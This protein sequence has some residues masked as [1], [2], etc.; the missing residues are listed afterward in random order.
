MLI[1]E[2]RVY[3]LTISALLLLSFVC[4]WMHVHPQDGAL[5][6]IAAPTKSATLKA[7][8]RGMVLTLTGSV[9]DQA[10]KV[11]LI[12]SAEKFFGRAN[13]VDQIEIVANIPAPIWVEQ[14]RA[15]FPLLKST[16]KNGAFGFKDKSVEVSGLVSGEEAKTKILRSID[17]LAGANL[18][19]NDQLVTPSARAVQSVKAGP[20]QLKLN[21]LLAGQTVEFD[22]GSSRLHSDNQKLLDAIVAVLKTDSNAQI[23][24]SGYTDNDGR[25]DKNV[26]LSQR[27]A[28]AVKQY[29]V[30]RGIKKARIEAIGHGSSLPIADE[31]TA[32]GPRKNRRIEFNVRE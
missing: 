29:L 28:D 14:A 15:I 16:I 1:T 9:P 26:R 4:I 2:K 11:S 25:E 23:E 27:R 32:A 17:T 7:A 19:V 31:N 13:V 18:T 24:I 22:S 20:L 10:T 3:I 8:V 12:N 30:E 5:A 21:E 6:A